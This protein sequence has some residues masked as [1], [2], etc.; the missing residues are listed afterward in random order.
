LEALKIE[1]LQIQNSSKFRLQRSHKEQ[2]T[3]WS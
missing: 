1:D 2:K 3:H